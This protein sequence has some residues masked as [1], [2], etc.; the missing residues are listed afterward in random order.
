MS[1]WDCGNLEDD[2]QIDLIIN[3]DTILSNFSL[4]YT[5]HTINVY[6]ENGI[7]TLTVHADNEGSSPPNTACLEISNVISGMPSQDWSLYQGQNDTMN[8]TVQ[9]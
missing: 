5:K 2:D 4:T 6:L 9:Y 7:N 3:G 1:V 8:I